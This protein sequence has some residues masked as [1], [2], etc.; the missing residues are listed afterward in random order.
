M[1]R[2]NTREPS[3]RLLVSIDRANALAGVTTKFPALAFVGDADD[4]RSI[5]E[6]WT[7]AR[8][9]A[10][11]DD[12]LVDNRV[13]VRSGL[14]RE[15]VDAVERVLGGDI[16]D[17][18]LLSVMHHEPGDGQFDEAGF[19]RHYLEDR[20]WPREKV[21]RVIEARETLSPFEKDGL[22]ARLAELA[23]EAG[24]PLASHDDETAADV[25]RMV[26]HAAS[27]SEYPLTIE[28]A[29]RAVDRVT[30]N[31]AEAVGLHDRGRLEAGARADVIV[32]DPSPTPI[33]ERVFV[34]GSEVF[35]AEPNRERTVYPASSGGSGA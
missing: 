12:T 6:A 27:I 21:E 17:V 35:R 5:D 8:A 7:L 22:V 16:V 20:D 14:S 10:V 13:H 30:R 3:V 33:V 2:S 34:A 9:V 23:A 25:D 19:E 26:G 29:E 28:A 18:D 1:T 11:D 32:V 15:S 4:A 24:V 31:P